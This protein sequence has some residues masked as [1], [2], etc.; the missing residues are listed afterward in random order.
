MHC[1]VAEPEPL[2]HAGQEVL[3]DHVGAAR[4]LE[5]QPGA[6]GLLEID[7]DAPL[8]A[9]DRRER[10]AHLAVAA[11]RAQVV[12]TAGPLQLDHVGAQVAQE[13]RAVGPGDDAGEIEDPDALEHGGPGMVPWRR[14]RVKAP[15]G[16]LDDAPAGG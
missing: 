4:E 10:G 1:R 15:A 5:G 9:V 14:P 16:R 2:R 8:V 11:Q 7:R 12:A 3:D 13:G 6:V